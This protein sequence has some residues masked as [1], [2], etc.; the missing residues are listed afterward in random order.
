MK[1]SGLLYLGH[2]VSKAGLKVD[3]NEV[4]AV[5]SWPKPKDVSGL[6]AFLGLTNYFSSFNPGSLP[7]T[8]ATNVFAVRNMFL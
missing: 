5:E 1:Q 3:P 6:R 7:V 8:D 4:A 2:S